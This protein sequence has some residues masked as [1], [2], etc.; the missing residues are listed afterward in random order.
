[1]S[2]IQRVAIVTGAAGGIGRAMTRAL[3]AGGIQIAGVARDRE[4]LEALAASAR[5]QGKAADLLTIQTDR[6]NDSAAEEITKATRDRSASTFSLTTPA[7]A[8]AE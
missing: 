2:E 4:P 7:S 8:R 6:T 5:E 1:M 3:L